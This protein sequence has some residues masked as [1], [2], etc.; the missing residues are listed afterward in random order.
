MQGPHDSHVGTR[1][2]SVRGL[3]QD[4][5]NEEGSAGLCTDDFAP[6]FNLNGL[7]LNY[8]EALV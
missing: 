1:S 8:P 3:A 6:S 2:T 4:Q 7:N 5:H